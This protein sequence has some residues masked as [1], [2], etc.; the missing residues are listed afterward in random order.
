MRSDPIL[1]DGLP[2]DVAHTAAEAMT[3][4]LSRCDAGAA[5]EAWF[6]RHE[7]ADFMTLRVLAF[8]KASVQM[9]R[10]AFA[11][12]GPRLSKAV[13]LAPPEWADRLSH[14]MA[15]VFAV[16]HPVPTERNLHAARALA[17]CALEAPEDEGVLAL[18]SGGG[19]AHL[20]LPRT[21]ITLDHIREVT[22]SLL[23]AGAPIADLNTVR[24]SME[25]LKGGGLRAVC[26]ARRMFALIVSDVI[27]D[28]PATIAS[29]PLAASEAADPAGVLRQWGVTV[30]PAVLSVMTTPRTFADR[31]PAVHE[32]VLSGATLTRSLPAAL[33]VDPGPGASA[34]RVGPVVQP[35]TGEAASVGADLAARFLAISAGRPDEPNALLA[36]G[37]PTVTVGDA[38]GL[39]GRALELALS[40][41]RSL[42]TDRPWGLLSLAT[43]G[44]DGPTDAAGAVLCSEM[45]QDPRA[46]TLAA[47]A[48]AKHDS[49]HAVEMLGGLVKTGPTGTNLNDVVLIWWRQA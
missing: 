15:E 14:P 43:D 26:P 38:S 41:A 10:A 3:R 9:A 24:R 47:N 4:I 16:D 45:F 30:D 34:I 11:R 17:A 25:Q 23:R 36:W 20:T 48:L 29:G 31:E 35:V 21:G 7:L 33:G 18:I 28:D 12:L 40:A 6:K 46:M 27:G 37:E 1:P 49:Y 2:S 5:T 22:R 44:V 13:V 8:G 39:G 32:I 42:P 19:S